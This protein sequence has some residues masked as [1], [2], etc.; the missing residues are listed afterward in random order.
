MRKFQNLFEQLRAVVEWL[1][2]LPV[3]LYLGGSSLGPVSQFSVV[4]QFSVVHECGVVD[5]RKS[6]K[7]DG[8]RKKWRD[9]GA[10]F[11]IFCP[12]SCVCQFS[13]VHECGVVDARKSWKRERD[14][15]K[16]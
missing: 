16:W 13:V 2:C 7:R 4:V 6:W 15:K 11:S 9:K 10:V 12:S 14:R 8:E 5:A 1:R 3:V